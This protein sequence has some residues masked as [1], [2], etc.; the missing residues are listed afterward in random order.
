MEHHDNH[1]H[2]SPSAGILAVLVLSFSPCAL[3]LAWVIHLASG[4]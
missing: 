3:T 1:E 4:G 2:K